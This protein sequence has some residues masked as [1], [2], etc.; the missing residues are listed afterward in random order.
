MLD[1]FSTGVTASS[2]NSYTHISMDVDGVPATT[3]DGR[4][5]LS[6]ASRSGTK[7]VNTKFNKELPT[8]ARTIEDPYSSDE[9]AAIGH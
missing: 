6:I 2:D 4:D 7:E 3:A 8:T 1:E 5:F 9:A